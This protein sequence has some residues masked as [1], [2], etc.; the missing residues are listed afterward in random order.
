MPLDQWT[1]DDIGRALCILS[2]TAPSFCD[3]EAAQGFWCV[4]RSKLMEWVGISLRNGLPI[5]STEAVTTGG[6]GGQ[7]FL[8][9]RA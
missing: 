1:A 5:G 8:T 9:K 6:Y 4:C 2:G 7:E 3:D